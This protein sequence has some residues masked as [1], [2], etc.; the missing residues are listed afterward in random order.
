MD[1]A[2]EIFD[3]KEGEDLDEHDFKNFEKNLPSLR[4]R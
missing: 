4:Y 1:R 2:E 3:A